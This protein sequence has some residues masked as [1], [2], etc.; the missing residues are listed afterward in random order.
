[1]CNIIFALCY[2]NV[3]N[4]IAYVQSHLLWHNKEHPLHDKHRS[5]LEALYLGKFYLM[6][7]PFKQKFFKKAPE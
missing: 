5:K 3:K 1:M 4:W 6:T 7:S 2:F